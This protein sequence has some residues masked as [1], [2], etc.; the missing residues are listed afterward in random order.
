MKKTRLAVVIAG[1]FSA[2]VFAQSN[3][4]MGYEY[5]DALGENQAE[6]N[7]TATDDNKIS[8]NSHN[9]VF[10][11]DYDIQLGNGFSVAPGVKLGTSTAAI[12]DVTDI[13]ESDNHLVLGY[14]AEALVRA[15]FTYNKV[16]AFVTPGYEMLAITGQTAAADF[17]DMEHG[18]ALDMGL[19]Y[20]IS[21]NLSIEANAGTSWVRNADQNKIA[22][23]DGWRFGGALRFSF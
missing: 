20:N 5:Q 12:S 19:G 11:Y 8:A 1:M 7:K 2:S 3:I 15:Q 13:A 4:S 21:K 14:K 17:S 16:F 18:F 22:H 10:G 6:L 23:V 9:I